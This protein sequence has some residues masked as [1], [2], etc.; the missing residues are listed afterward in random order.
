MNQ[1]EDRIARQLAHE[2][3]PVLSPFFASRVMHEIQRRQR[4]PRPMPLAMRLYW[5]GLLIVTIVAVN[6]IAIEVD[7]GFMSLV[8]VPSGF[9]VWIYRSELAVSALNLSRL[10][11]GSRH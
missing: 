10:L 3:K 8:L 9:A 6:A 2:P 5:L 1:D 11:L 4:L 7:F